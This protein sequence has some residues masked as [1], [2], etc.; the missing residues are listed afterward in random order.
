MPRQPPLT[1]HD[2]LLPSIP[3]LYQTLFLALTHTLQHSTSPCSPATRQASQPQHSQQ[4]E[5]C[6]RNR[7]AG[8]DTHT[9][10]HTCNARTE[11]HTH[12]HKH[13]LTLTLTHAHKHHSQTHTGSMPPPPLP[14]LSYLLRFICHSNGIAATALA[15]TPRTVGALVAVVVGLP[16]AAGPAGGAAAHTSRARAWSLPL[17]PPSA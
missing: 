2:C 17:P 4:A 6:G 5:H 12:T 10:T 15:S 9:H 8:P 11:R 7:C 3:L 1:T 14:P 13:T 16:G